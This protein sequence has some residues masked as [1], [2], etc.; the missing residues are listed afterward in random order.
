MALDNGK[1]TDRHK[2][3]ILQLVNLKTI[4]FTPYFNPAIRTQIEEFI[5]NHIGMVEY[6]DLEQE[7]LRT[8]NMSSIVKKAKQEYSFNS[9]DA[10]LLLFEK[11]TIQIQ[12]LGGLGNKLD[13]LKVTLKISQTSNPILGYRDSVNL[14]QRAQVANLIR[15]ASDTLLME[16]QS[17]ET[18]I[19]ELV[20]CLETYRIELKQASSSKIELPTSVLSSSK[21]EA[22]QKYLSS[23]KLNERLKTD[24][25]QIGISGENENLEI[26]FYTMTSRLL[27]YPLNVVIHAGSGSG[28]SALM[29]AVAECMPQTE[30]IEI[31]SISQKSFYHWDEHYLTNKILLIQDWY[32]LDPEIEYIIREIQSKRKVSRVLTTRDKNNSLVSTVKEVYGPVSVISA[33][34][35]HAIYEDNANRSIQ[36]Y[37][38]ESPDQDKRI[39]ERQLQLSARGVNIQNEKL[40]KSKLKDAQVLL[41]PYVVKNRFAPYLQLPEGVQQVRRMNPIYLNLIASVTLFHQF[42]RKT[43]IDPQTGEIILLS[44]IEDIEIANNLMPQIL[45]SKIDLLSNANREFYEEL[46]TWLKK[47]KLDI[48]GNKEIAR[49]MR[50]H[51]SKVKR[52]I[53]SLL[54]LGYIQITGGDRYKTGYQ[55]QVTDSEEYEQLKAKVLEALSSSLKEIKH[56]F[57]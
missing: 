50:L 23:P 21:K 11:E 18:C 31:T 19:Q 20:S 54:E 6:L 34:T 57:G 46:K 45:V 42:Q 4:L 47:N 16:T 9:D 56:R 36:L 25:Q 38:N 10:E 30:Y 39:I 35:K 27:A 41:K 24:L 28:K 5:E 17:L 55:Y 3:A 53:K 40:V 13:Q 15:E 26:L 14:Y 51:P 52:Q 7:E 43:E 29:E 1:F 48:F 22:A 12:I 37:L 49:G 2:E 32:A 33:T 44:Q 8:E